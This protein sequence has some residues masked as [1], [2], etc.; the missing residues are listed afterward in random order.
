[1]R[2]L[3]PI[4]AMGSGLMAIVV[5]VLSLLMAHGTIS[6]MDW[7]VEVNSNT[8]VNDISA[9]VQYGIQTGFGV[10]AFLLGIF[11]FKSS[12]GFAAFI[13]LVIFGAATG[14]AL[15]TGFK[16]DSWPTMSIVFVSVYSVATF[17][18]LLG[19]FAPKN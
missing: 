11:A 1:M 17:G 9:D 5:G 19:L 18:L 15:Y 3:G 12:R 16:N 8:H 2:K 4:M 7:V 14:F 6:S 13:L 10:V